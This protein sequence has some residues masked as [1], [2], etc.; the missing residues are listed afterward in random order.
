M[1]ELCDDRHFGSNITVKLHGYC[2]GIVM[3]RSQSDFLRD[4]LLLSTLLSDKVFIANLL[5]FIRSTV[6]SQALLLFNHCG[7]KLKIGRA[8]GPGI[9]PDMLTV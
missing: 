8:A 6:T 5:L 3:P 2:K 9:L 7:M 4:H 1:V